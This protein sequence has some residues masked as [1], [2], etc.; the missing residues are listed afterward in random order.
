MLQLTELQIT[1]VYVTHDRVE[2]LALSD[3]IAVMR[4]GAIVEEGEPRKIYFNSDH[5]FEADFIGRANLIPGEVSSLENGH[6]VIET[7]I[8]PVVG[9][10]SQEIQPGTEAVLCVRPEFMHLATTDESGS[11]NVFQGKVETLVFVGEA[12]E[13]DI[14][15]GETILTTTIPPTVDISA[16][17]DLYISFDSDHCFLLPV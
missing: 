10:N 6:A 7:G 14:R 12:Y 2:A 11:R 9:V 15:I 13:G 8:G 1:A 3:R 16:G 17:D 4:A 5:Q